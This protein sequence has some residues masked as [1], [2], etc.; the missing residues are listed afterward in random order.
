MLALMYAGQVWFLRHISL[1]FFSKVTYH[2]ITTKKCSLSK[3][4]QVMY[5]KLCNQALQHNNTSV[6]ALRDK[7]CP[8]P[9]S[10][11]GGSQ[12]QAP[13]LEV[14][15]QA[16]YAEWQGCAAGQGTTMDTWH[17]SNQ[18]TTI[19]GPTRS[20]SLISRSKWEA[21]RGSGRTREASHK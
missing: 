13:H 15:G 5:W 11:S 18:R 12:G 7:G 8:E 9:P 14:V 4:K 2:L 17:R 16:K 21:T 3:N 1:N 20:G 10:K 19:E 6:S